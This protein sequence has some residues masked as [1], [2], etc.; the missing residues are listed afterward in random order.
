MNKTLVFAVIIFIFLVSPTVLADYY[1]FMCWSV[2]QQIDF[3]ECNAA[4]PIRTCNSDPYCRA[5]VKVLSNGT[6]CH[7]YDNKC[8]VG[9]GGCV[10]AG[11][12]TLDIT[13]PNITVSSPVNG[14]I[15]GSRYVDLVIGLSEYSTL[16]YIDNSYIY[17]RNMPLCSSC[18]SYDR[19]RT[20]NEGYNDLQIVARDVIGNVAES[21][22]VFT[23]DSYAPRINQI[24]PIRG[25]A[26]GNFMVKFVE[27]NPAGVILHYG[28]SGVYNEEP[29]DI[30]AECLL[31]RGST[32]CETYVDLS[33]YNPGQVE[34][35]FEVIDIAGTSV[36]SMKKI[37]DVDTVEPNILNLEVNPKGA[38]AKFDVE[39]DELNFLSGQYYD[40]N[41]PYPRWNTLCYRL[42]G[43]KC[44]GNIR[45]Y[46]GDHN[47]KIKISDKA[48]N[49]AT[50][51]DIMFFTDSILP[52]IYSTKPSRGFADGNFEVRF[53]EKNPVLLE[54]HYGNLGVGYN[55]KPLDLVND[56]GVERGV[57]VCDTYVDL[58][59][60]DP[61]SIEYWFELTDK[62]GASASSRK[63]TLQV[64]TTDPDILSTTVDPQGAYVEFTLEVEEEN[65]LT[66]EYIDHESRT[67]RW[68]RLCYSLRNG[69]CKGK[70]RFLDGDHDVDIRIK[71]KAGN[72]NTVEDITFF[73]DSIKPRIYSTSPTYGYA[74]GS[75]EVKF[76][77]KN[78][79]SLVLIYGNDVD[80]YND[81]PVD[82]VNDCVT[83]RYLEKCNLDVDIS[84]YHGSKIKYWFELED[85]AGAVVTSRPYTLSVDTL[86][87][88][89]TTPL[90]VTH[91]HGNYYIFT[92]GAEDDNFKDVKYYDHDSSYPRWTNLCYRLV[93]GV[94]T[95]T[96][97]FA[98]GFHTIDVRVNDKAGNYAEACAFIDV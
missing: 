20:F 43:N 23:I 98:D 2:G 51:T 77:E 6:V 84:G 45:F 5:C 7:S 13:P 27:K 72:E 11:N 25:F 26:D 88:V 18:D 39:I 19:T 70:P 44:S 89:I 28:L 86:D 71:D 4:V 41:S 10:F 57:N 32:T 30:G 63:I 79:T 56:C 42:T 35:W 40:N 80:G 92:I 54:L 96:R 95:S 17:P 8:N 33:A 58:S 93:D 82:L 53:M 38:Y 14:S 68:T 75:F 59:A 15:L 74:D 49:D 47:V 94:C 81:E 76:I 22:L 66:G 46:D 62:A 85:R 37:L 83:E 34:Y 24:L 29:L 16:S 36:E 9:G 65:F 73:T 61:G 3:T 21:N 78:P 1:T 91:K 12:S 52:R 50:I 87:P 60:Y 48:G 64:D 90:E 67:P 31:D 55:V 97:Y 69:E